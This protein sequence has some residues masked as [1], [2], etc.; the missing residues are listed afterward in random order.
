MVQKITCFGY[1]DL[2]GLG[3]VFGN[4][5]NKKQ[6]WKYLLLILFMYWLLC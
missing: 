6:Q 1:Q 5:K 3:A 4:S 2:H